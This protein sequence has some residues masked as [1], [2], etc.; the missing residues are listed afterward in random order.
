MAFDIVTGMCIGI[1]TY[2]FS[3]VT[4]VRKKHSVFYSK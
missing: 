4:Q 3:Q 1:A 2:G